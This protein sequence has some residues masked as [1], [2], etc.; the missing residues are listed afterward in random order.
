MILA[1]YMHGFVASLVQAAFPAV[2]EL[3]GDREAVAALYR[4]A[5]KI[6]LAIVVFVVT[7]FVTCGAL[8]L[9]LWVNAELSEGSE[10][11]L[12]LH[13][14]SFSVIA[15]GIMALQIAEAF[16]FPV[17]GVILTL[18]WMILGIPLMIFGA[19]IWGAEG[20]AAARFVATLTMIPVI[21]YSEH[22]FLGA[23]QWRFWIAVGVRIVV[24]IAV[25]ILVQEVA[26]SFIG[27][28]HVSLLVAGFVGGL[29]Y[30]ATLYVAGFVTEEDKEVLRWAFV[31]KAPKVAET[32]E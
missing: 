29:S 5:S 20:V 3:L 27:Q 7:T 15:V 16:R 6:V 25:T 26:L 19:D 22:R 14:L 30:L 18:A 11:L 32:T 10:T 21:I 1:I 13:G 9:K 24:A 4:R 23:F 2:N 12:V 31:R 28:P 17:L 8:F